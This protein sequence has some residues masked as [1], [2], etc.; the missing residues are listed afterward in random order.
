MLCVVCRMPQ[1]C[2]AQRRYLKPLLAPSA[3]P[4]YLGTVQRSA[5]L[6]N[7]P[8]AAASIHSMLQQAAVELPA[9]VTAGGESSAGPAAAAGGHPM[10]MAQQPLQQREAGPLALPLAQPQPNS[11]A[12][13]SVTQW[14]EAAAA[15]FMQESLAALGGQP[16]KGGRQAEMRAHTWD[17]PRDHLASLAWAGRAGGGAV[18]DG[19]P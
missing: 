18:P 15:T 17:S 4:Q 11:A 14:L 9:N 8:P 1:V 12:Q 6:G 16:G 7:L 3:L 10:Q 5:G 19:E 13:R 2:F